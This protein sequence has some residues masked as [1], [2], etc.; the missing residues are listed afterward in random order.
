VNRD[1]P[2]SAQAVAAPVAQEAG[3]DPPRRG[4]MR[5]RRANSPRLDSD[6]ARRQGEITQLAFHLLGR[7]GA[8]EFLN[9]EHAELGARPLDLATASAAG[10]ATVEEALGRMTV[11]QGE[12]N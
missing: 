6:S 8:I 5:F 9:N 4:A 1:S 12:D 11:R 10:C 7:E 2:P 3:Q